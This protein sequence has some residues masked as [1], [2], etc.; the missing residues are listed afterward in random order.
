MTCTSEGGDAVGG[1]SGSCL[2]YTVAST[3]IENTSGSLLGILREL[4]VVQKVRVST[5]G[6]DLREGH[7]YLTFMAHSVG[8]KAVSLASWA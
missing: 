6:Q 3:G 2:T 4:V 7:A 5:Q 1:V 8:M